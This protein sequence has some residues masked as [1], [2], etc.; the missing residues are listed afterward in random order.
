MNKGRIQDEYRKNTGR[1]Q[2]EYRKNTGSIS[3][4][5]C[6]EKCVRGA[7]AG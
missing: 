4:G 5:E 6:S 1:I 3:K 2:E 7:I